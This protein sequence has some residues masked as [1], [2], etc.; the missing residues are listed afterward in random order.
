MLIRFEFIV[1]CY[2]LLHFAKKTVRCSSPS[3]LLVVLLGR[4]V[5]N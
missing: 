1:S 5:I 2:S 4:K 3:L